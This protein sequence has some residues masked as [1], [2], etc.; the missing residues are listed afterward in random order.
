MNHTIYTI[1]YSGFQR[2]QFVAAIA[3][4]G[5]HTVIDVRSSP[6]SHHSPEYDCTAIEARL[7]KDGILY[8]SYAEEF[9]ARQENPAFYSRDGIMDFECFAKSDQ[10]L[11]GVEKVCKAME[12][13][14]AL[15]CKEEQPIDCHRAILVARAFHDRGYEVK[16]LCPDGIITQ[17]DLEEQLLKRYFPDRA[18]CPGGGR[19]R[20]EL[21]KEA[22]R[23][24]NRDIGYHRKPDA[25]P[26]T[27]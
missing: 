18:S 9:G 10:F 11:R 14:V 4:L 6:Y 23:L 16:H 2:E 26:K 20:A 17:E 3:G 22:Y 1:G 13:G 7:K 8:K 21:L 19:P 15:M 27:V 12:E 25:D 24:C 5:I